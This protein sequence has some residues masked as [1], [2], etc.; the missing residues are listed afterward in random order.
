MRPVIHSGN[1]GPRYRDTADV[2]WPAPA[3]AVPLPLPQVSLRVDGV[4]ADVL[5]A[6]PVDSSRGRA[7]G[8][9]K[10]STDLEPAGDVSIAGKAG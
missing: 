6:V 5:E 4:D 10:Y 1:A 3:I 2:A 7:P 8:L 9:S